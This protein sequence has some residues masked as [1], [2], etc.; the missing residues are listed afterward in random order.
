MRIQK[1][2]LSNT[3]DSIVIFGNKENDSGGNTLFGEHDHIPLETIETRKGDD[4]LSEQGIEQVDLLKIDVEGAEMFVLG[5]LD[6]YLGEKRV[7][8]MLIEANEQRLR[9]A[10]SSP[11]ELLNLIR[12]KGFRV[13][14]IRK[15]K[16]TIERIPDGVPV[17]NVA[18]W[19]ET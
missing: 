6:R 19:L 15:P 5:G 11:A 10:G 9:A 18:C 13:A 3:A 4:V 1:I 8:A 14:D 2:G 7:K 12:S 17:V 16:H